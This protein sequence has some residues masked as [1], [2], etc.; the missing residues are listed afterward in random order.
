[1]IEE[2][3]HA[4]LSASSAHRWLVCTPSVRLEEQFEDKE[5]DYAKEGTLAHAIAEF[6]VRSYFLEPISKRKRTA[7]LKKFQKEELYDAEMITHTENYLEY[8]KQIAMQY[9][10]PPFISV[11]K[12]VCYGQYARDGFGTADCIVICGDTLHIVDFKYG[13][14]VEVSAID[15]VQLK[16]YALGALQEYGIFYP[17]S[18]VKLHIFQPRVDNISEYSIDRSMLEA[19]GESIKEKAQLAYDGKGEFVSG[20]HCRFCKAKG[21][22][23]A[24]ATKNVQTVEECTSK[25]ILTHQEVR[26]NSFKNERRR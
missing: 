21:C 14:G 19:W 2:K 9:I 23:K 17:I 13:K 1:M 5:S 7:E 11:E 4:V 26:R 15:N 10:K 16:L 25:A 18:T 12:R 24:R 6:Q 22:C 20:E 3:E 8:I